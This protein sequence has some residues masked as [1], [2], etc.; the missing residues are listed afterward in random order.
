MS[1]FL[2]I[3]TIQTLTTTQT[4]KQSTLSLSLSLALALALARARTV[5]R[6]VA[7]ARTRREN[8]TQAKKNTYLPSDHHSQAAKSTVSNSASTRPAAPCSSGSSPS[9]S[10][11]S[12]SC[13]R[14]CGCAPSSRPAGA[15]SDPAGLAGPRPCSFVVTANSPHAC[16]CAPRVLSA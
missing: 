12:G 6:T 3:R 4:N 1:L 8:R 14:G 11:R 13:S 15:P 9:H 5:A 16:S 2:L 10:A 7:R